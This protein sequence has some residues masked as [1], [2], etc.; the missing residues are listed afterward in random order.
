MEPKKPPQDFTLRVRRYNPESGEAPYWD[1]HTIQ[2]E[3]HRS[4][5]EGLLQAK[6][7]FDGSIGVRCSCK[8][9]ICGSCG[10]R[11][12]RPPGP[13]CHTHLSAAL[14]TAK[15]GVIEVEPMG[16]MPVI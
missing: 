3:P 14:K 15:N 9:A 7:R 1:E 8:A 10:V 5:L 2:L 13:P 16:N 12:N 11:V 6:G 4:V